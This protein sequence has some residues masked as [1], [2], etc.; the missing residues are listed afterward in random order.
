MARPFNEFEVLHFF[1]TNNWSANEGK[2]FFAY[3][4][5]RNWELS[6]GLKIKS[7]ETAARSYA[8][9]GFVIRK[10]R[11]NPFSGFVDNLKSGRNKNY[12]E[13]L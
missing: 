3:Y 1:K 11:T 13:P 5:S 4:Q 8:E 6:R 12:D 2:K 10:E 7:W 9:E